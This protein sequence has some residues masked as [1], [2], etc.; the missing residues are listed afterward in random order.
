MAYHN[1]PSQI[2][3]QQVLSN[4]EVRE[5]YYQKKTSARYPRGVRPQFSDIF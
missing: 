3:R 1:W 4:V 2:H 5:I